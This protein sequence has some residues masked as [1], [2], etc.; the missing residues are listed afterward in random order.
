MTHVKVA[1]AADEFKRIRTMTVSLIIEAK[2]LSLATMMD[3]QH[4]SDH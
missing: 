4:K 1:L 2:I 3:S